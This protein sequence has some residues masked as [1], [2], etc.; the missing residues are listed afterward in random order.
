M[1]RFR[2]AEA[3]AMRPSPCGVCQIDS[4]DSS[5]LRNTGVT[6]LKSAFA[7]TRLS[8]PSATRE[9]RKREDGPLHRAFRERWAGACCDDGRTLDP[10]R[11]APIAVAAW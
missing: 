4:G 10:W 1:R 2:R 6:T 9:P 3:N 5:H 7:H 8:G 11:C